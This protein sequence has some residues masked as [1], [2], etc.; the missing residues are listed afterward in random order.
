MEPLLCPPSVRNF[1]R[2]SHLVLTA[3]SA[4]PSFG[5][6]CCRGIS[7]WSSSVAGAVLFSCLGPGACQVLAQNS[8]SESVW[9]RHAC[10]SVSEG[11]PGAGQPCG[12]GQ[13][14]CRWR[15]HSRWVRPAGTHGRGVRRIAWK[16][17]SG[18]RAW[19]WAAA[20]Y[21]EPW[22]LGFK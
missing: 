11:S 17:P 12:L 18:Y 16:T 10:T 2:N 14:G 1:R 13:N 4:C 8:H 6:S 7:F 5:H 15:G 9:Q 19:R 20:V 21:G 3:R 22:N